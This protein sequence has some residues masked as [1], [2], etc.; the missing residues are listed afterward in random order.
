MIKRINT[1]KISKYITKDIPKYS[2]R[3]EL[4]TNEL[5]IQS[6]ATNFNHKNYLPI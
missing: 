5:W 1:F 4:S 3:F 6:S 2:M